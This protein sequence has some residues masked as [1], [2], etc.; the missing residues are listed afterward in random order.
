[1]N[2]IEQKLA[3][4]ANKP[5]KSYE[6]NPMDEIFKGELLEKAEEFEEK[7]NQSKPA[8]DS[9]T[10]KSPKPKK[11]KLRKVKRKFEGGEKE[12]KSTN[13]VKNTKPANKKP[14][15]K[16]KKKSLVNKKIKS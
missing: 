4:Q 3:A 11:K 13:S 10:A 14:G 5:E 6:L 7:E 15:L 9:S 2:R 8:S 1:M 16:I 12:N